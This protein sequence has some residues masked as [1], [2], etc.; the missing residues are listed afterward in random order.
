MSPWPLANE[1]LRLKGRGTRES[2][3][4]GA[5]TDPTALSLSH[6]GPSPRHQH[7]HPT[8]PLCGRRAKGEQEAKKSPG[9]GPR[10]IRA[11]PPH[12]FPLPCLPVGGGGARLLLPPRRQCCYGDRRYLATE[13]RGPGHLLP[14]L[15]LWGWTCVQKLPCLGKPTCGHKTG[16]P[17]QEGTSRAPPGS[18]SIRRR[19]SFFSR[20]GTI[21][22]IYGIT[23]IT[24]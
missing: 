21:V 16:R 11:E 24:L 18:V 3:E 6:G 12:H 15:W 17:G 9:G 2:V 23:K 14:L 5:R 7:L 10:G 13:L 1:K 19:L 22:L 20:L 8:A 4:E